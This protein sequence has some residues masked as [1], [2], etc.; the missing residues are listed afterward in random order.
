MSSPGPKQN[1]YEKYLRWLSPDR[2]VAEEKHKEITRRLVRFFVQQSCNESHECA[3]ETI[4]RVVRIIDSKEQHFDV[5]DPLRF[6]LGV[7]KNVEREHRKRRKKYVSLDDRDFP[8][9]VLDDLQEQKLKCLDGCLDKLP[10]DERNLMI[11]YHEGGRHEKINNRKKL[12]A[13]LGCTSTALRIKVCRINAKL[14]D[15]MTDCLNRA[16]N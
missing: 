6:C 11:R 3:S 9:K 7:A 14:Y 8:A 4:E 12:A 16:A 10:V 5:I 13:E 15:C 2:D 1:P